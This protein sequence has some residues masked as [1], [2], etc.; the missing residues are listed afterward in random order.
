MTFH[1]F[2]KQKW[3]ETKQ[4]S[5]KDEKSNTSTRCQVDQNGCNAHCFY[6]WG[7]KRH[8]KLSMN[9]KK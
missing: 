6:V 7:K 9:I 3:K 5:R 2:D 4:F 8:P 1:C